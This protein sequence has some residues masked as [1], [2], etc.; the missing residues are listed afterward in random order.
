M[1]I[2]PPASVI[3]AM[4]IAMAEKRGIDRKIIGGTVQNDMLTEFIA[5]KT[6]M[7]PPV[8]SVRIITD[9][10]EFGTR[11]IPRWNTISVSGYHIREAGST[12]A[13]QL[14]FPGRLTPWFGRT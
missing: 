1:T 10:V 12:A 5:Q 3:W 8:P 11:E 7:C 6:F 14:A 4:Y 13:K 2:N 9:T